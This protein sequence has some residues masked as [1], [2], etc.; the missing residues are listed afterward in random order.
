MLGSIAALKA[1]GGNRLL[2]TGD[3]IKLIQGRMGIGGARGPAGAAPVALP[4]VP[5]GQMRAFDP[6]G[7]PHL[8]PLGTALPPGW[9]VA[10]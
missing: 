1:E 8:A 4:P 7:A 9:T 2:S 3:Q 6:Q 5:A 10:R